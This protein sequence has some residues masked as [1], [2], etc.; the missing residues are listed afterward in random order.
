MNIIIKNQNYKM[1]DNSNIDVL[2]TLNGELTRKDLESNLIN[3]YYKKVV[4]DITAIKNYYDTTAL[5]NFLSYFDNPSKVILLLNDSEIVNSKNYLSNLIDNG[6][7]NFTRSEGMLNYLVEHPNTLD[8]VLKYKE[9]MNMNPLV[10]N[11]SISVNETKNDIVSSRKKMTIIG[12]QNVT[13]HAG[14][15]TLMYMFLKQLSL[16]Y[17]VKAFEMFKQDAIYFRNDDILTSTS[18]DDLKMKI[19]AL[20]DVEVVVVDLNGLAVDDLCDE[21]IYLIEP[22]VIRLNKL[23]K[24]NLNI[25][26]DI[27]SKKVVLNRSAI[28]NEEINEFEYETKMKVFYNLPNF[29]ER[30]ERLQSVDELLIK[31]GFSK[32]KP[33]K[34]FLGIFK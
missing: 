21:I 31:L 27:K 12:I 20:N 9:E 33:Q 25:L 23:L 34:G 15:T 30:R 8:D 18:L 1:L 3:L 26:E 24:S 4:I 32:Q 16:N 29:N 19:K 11:K 6:Y 22:G 10:S 13:D 28:K 5:L 17:K 2:K 7:Y 14:S